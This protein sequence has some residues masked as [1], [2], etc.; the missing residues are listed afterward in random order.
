[1][2]KADKHRRRESRE[3]VLACLCYACTSVSLSLANKYLFSDAS[4][5]FPFSVRCAT[6]C[7]RAQP[8]GRPG[9]GVSPAREARE[10]LD[11]S[12]LV[13]ST[14]SIRRDLDPLRRRTHPSP[15][16]PTLAEP[17]ADI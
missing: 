12:R 15:S 1:M 4:F 7:E 9:P 17:R 16:L 13:T 11:R 2:C 3:A 6:L 5:D 8:C 10:A 14:R